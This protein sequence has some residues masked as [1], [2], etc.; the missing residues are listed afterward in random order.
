MVSSE[1]IHHVMLLYL[2][3][4]TLLYN[5]SIFR[6][7]KLWIVLAECEKE[8]GLPITQD[9]IDEMIANEYNIDFELADKKETEFRHDVMAHIHTFGITGSSLNTYSHCIL[10]LTA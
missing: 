5:P 1:E 7:R 9:Q 10:P 4:Y 8:L 3:L 6:W 2:C